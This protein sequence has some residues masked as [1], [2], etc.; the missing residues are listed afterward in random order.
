MLKETGERQIKATLVAVDFDHQMRYAF[1]ASLIPSGARVADVGCG[2]G[3]GSYYMACATDCQSVIGIDIA[4][5]AIA[6]AKENYYQAKVSFLT[7]DIMQGQRD[8]P[9][10]FD[11]I[12]AFEVVEHVPDSLN[13]LKSISKLLNERG[14]AIFTT[15]NQDVLPYDKEM[16]KF[17]CRHFTDAEIETLVQEAGMEILHHFSQNGTVVYGFAGNAFH[18]LVCRKA[19][20]DVTVAEGTAVRNTRLN[21][22]MASFERADWLLE[23]VPTQD[24]GA[25][26]AQL[27]QASA[28]D[29]ALRRE[30]IARKDE[31][32]RKY[33]PQTLTDNPDF[34]DV[35]GELSVGDVVTQEF[36]CNDAS[37][38]GLSFLPALYCTEFSG[39]VAVSLFDEQ[40]KLLS[41][42]HI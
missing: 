30:L 36:L 7:D 21:Q 23:H 8:Y 42:I 40:N 15:P 2:I 33:H 5:E 9:N 41:L 38:C 13:F 34:V 1:A 12:T 26:A 10:R 28:Y 37:L 35:V 24:I 11:V 14:V 17:H 4:Q 39:L 20:T 18:V 32:N 3:Y 22:S 25:L 16:F 29:D 6:Y 19:G 27:K 31:Y